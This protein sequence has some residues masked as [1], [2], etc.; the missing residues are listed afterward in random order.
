[1]NRRRWLTMI[2]SVIIMS[3]RKRATSE[4][5]QCEFI[6]FWHTMTILIPDDSRSLWLRKVGLTLWVIRLLLNYHVLNQHGRSS[7]MEQEVEQ[8]KCNTPEWIGT[9]LW[10]H[11]KML[12]INSPGHL[13][14]LPLD[15]NSI[16]LRS[17]VPSTKAQF[18]SGLPSQMLRG[19]MHWQ[20]VGM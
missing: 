18:S 2:N 7:R 11:I 10:I 20:E 15:F 6:T 19:I 5:Q 16:I 14:Q 12:L 1:M 9:I 17:L 13:P 8:N 3:T 4:Y